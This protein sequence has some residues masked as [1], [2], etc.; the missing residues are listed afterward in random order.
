MSPL[1]GIAEMLSHAF[2]VRALVVGVLVSLCASMLGV[3]LLLKRYAMIGHGLADVGFASLS[4]SLALGVAPLYIAT[5]VLVVASFAIMAAS[6]RRG[7]S[8][9]LAVGMISTGAM[10]VG[11]IVTALTRGFNIDVYN[12]MFGSVLAMDR[13]DV[14][15]SVAVSLAVIAAFIVFYNRLFLMTCDEDYARAEGLNPTGWR[16]LVSLLTA[17]TV[18]VGMRIMGTLLISAL[19]IFPAVTAGRLTSSFRGLVTASAA[20]SVSCFAVGM[21]A[22]YLLDLPTGASVVA[23]NMAML[24]VAEGVRRVT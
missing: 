22:S 11:I 19:I 9:D 6:Q 15:L 8:G 14:V 13:S 3:I 10:S 5:P 7:A 20:V 16:F 1:A 23:V 2:V 17:L 4:I 18:S 21:A 12:Y 24:A